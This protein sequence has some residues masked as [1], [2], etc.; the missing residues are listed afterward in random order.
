MTSKH[1]AIVG[2][3]LLLVGFVLLVVWQASTNIERRKADRAGTGIVATAAKRTAELV[4][5][6]QCN[7]IGNKWD[8]EVIRIP[9]Q[10]CK[11]TSKKDKSGVTRKSSTC[12]T[13]YT[14]DVVWY[15]R[16]FV[17]MCGTKNITIV[18]SDKDGIWQD[19]SFICE[20]G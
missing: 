2:N 1:I 9:T 3:L 12:Q 19:G 18:C 17:Y 11:E 7:Q 4:S 6:T 20:K 14:E 8:D 10:K 5:A 13:T 15:K 16:V